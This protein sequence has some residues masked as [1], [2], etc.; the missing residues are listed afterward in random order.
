MK[1][2]LF[3]KPKNK[4]ILIERDSVSGKI[5]SVSFGGVLLPFKDVFVDAIIASDFK[6]AEYG[7]INS[8]DVRSPKEA[9]S[10]SGIVLVEPSVDER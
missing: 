9:I 10:F 1:E 5:V 4:Y 3:T 2:S 6:E 8:A 7:R